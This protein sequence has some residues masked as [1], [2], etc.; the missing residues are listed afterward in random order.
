MGVLSLLVVNQHGMIGERVHGPVEVS[1][2]ADTVLLLRH[3]EAGGR[4]RKAISVLKKRHGPHETSIRELV[5]VP[6]QV[7]VGAP[8]E[9]FEGVLTGRPEFRGAA[10]DL[11][12]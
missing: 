3:F 12:E 1:Y 7:D 5:L 4:V 11:R 2:L 6:G 9:E 8:L 10:R